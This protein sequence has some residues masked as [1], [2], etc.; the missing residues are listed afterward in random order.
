MNRWTIEHLSQLDPAELLASGSMGMEALEEAP[1]CLWK[2]LLAVYLRGAAFLNRTDSV[3]KGST[4]MPALED[5]HAAFVDPPRSSEQ[6]L[7]PEKYWNEAERDDPV[8]VRLE[9]VPEG[10]TVQVQNTLGELG[11]A[12]V[13]EPLEK[14]KGLK[15]QWGAMS[16]KFTNEAAAGWGGDRFV[17]LTRG[18]DRAVVRASA[19][20]TALR[21]RR[22]SPRPC[23]GL[24]EHLRGGGPPPWRASAASR[25]A[26][27]SCACARSRS[28]SRARRAWTKPA[29]RRSSAAC[30]SGPSAERRA[31]RP[32]LSRR[33]ARCRGASGCRRPRG[34]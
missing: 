6:I 33:P 20:G 14:R 31:T 28:C 3:M 8:Q 9:G 17:V 5:F 30:R 1:P 13:T 26:G 16:A 2:P 22:S 19:C 15:G 25:P 34:R 18:E 24:E 10:W 32:R 23:G 12:F 7:H 21:R 11:L 27:T 4:G 29:W